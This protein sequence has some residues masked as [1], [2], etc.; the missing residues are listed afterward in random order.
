M[1][2]VWDFSVLTNVWVSTDVHYLFTHS[3]NFHW[4]YILCKDVMLKWGIRYNICHQKVQ[5][6]A[7]EIGSQTNGT[8]KSK[9]CH[10][11]GIGNEY[12]HN[13][14]RESKELIKKNK[15]L[16]INKL[17]IEWSIEDK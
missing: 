1:L 13:I 3:G 17:I 7:V 6:S 9:K 5:S 11:K 2:Y 4:I 12:V 8:N 15:P 16:K 14:H 10:F